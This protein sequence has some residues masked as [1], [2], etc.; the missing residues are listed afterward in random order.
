M[1]RLIHFYKFSPINN[2][3]IF[4]Q[5]HKTRCLQLDLKGR[6]YIASEGI[7][8]TLGG[9]EKNIQTYKDCLRSQD[10]FADVFFKEEPSETMPFFQLKVKL[11]KEIVALKYPSALL[12]QESS[13]KFLEP[14][15][16]RKVLESE[17][18]FVLLDVRNHY[19]SKIG[20]FEGAVVP[21]VENFFDFPHWLKSSGLDRKKKVLMYCT[22]GIRCERF[23]SVMKEEGFEDVY[24]L[25]GGIINYAHQERG[26]HFKGKCFVFDDRLAIP[27]NP[28]DSEPISRCELS[29][30]P[31]DTYINCANDRCNR[32]FL[33]SQEAAIQ[34]DGACCEDCRRS[35]HKRPFDAD[36]IYA[37]YRKWYHYTQS[38]K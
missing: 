23:S 5:D 13:V 29:G 17:K 6:V 7:N 27:V 1:Y 21:E 37:P 2:V 32:L 10:G 3:P 36:N 38:Q 33:C 4:W 25:K 20:H 9:I 19:E 22:G 14:R 16:W 12:P 15:E 31:C 34:M 30:V 35:P 26:A 8:G 24:Q 11:R 28:Q 18:D